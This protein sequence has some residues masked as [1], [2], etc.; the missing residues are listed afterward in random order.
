M[1]N[2]QS[3]RV[4]MLGVLLGVA[5]SLALTRPMKNKIFGLTAF[6]PLTFA[7]VIILLTS[8][9]LRAAGLPAH[10]ASKVDPMVALRAE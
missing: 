2:G 9:A 8:A 5:G 6:D 7:A 10:R 3:M 4:G 1:G